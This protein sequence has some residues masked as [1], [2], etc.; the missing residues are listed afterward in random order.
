M[1][2]LQY[3]IGEFVKPEKI[4]SIIIEEW[5]NSIENLPDRLE[6]VLERATKEDLETPYRPEGWTVRQV[7]HHI[8]DSHL[9]SFIRFKL[10]LTEDNPTIKPYLEARWA[11]LADYNTDITI[12][13][14]IIKNIHLRWVALLRAMR[15]NDMERK[16]FHP[17]QKKYFTLA[18]NIGVY[19][20]HGSHHLAHILLVIDRT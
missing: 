17:E 13:L 2:H 9:N 10:A 18:E 19:A 5:I 6:K 8:A 1:Y 20:W 4:N 12:S 11:E 7:V 3:P 14:N 16:F 15:E